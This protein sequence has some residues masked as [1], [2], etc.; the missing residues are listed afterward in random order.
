MAETS[1]PIAHMLKYRMR[2]WSCQRWGPAAEK[3]GYG[4]IGRLPFDGGVEPCKGLL[5]FPGVETVRTTCVLGISGLGPFKCHNYLIQYQ[6]SRSEN[7]ENGRRKLCRC[8][9]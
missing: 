9:T 3:A 8:L 1:L 5:L 7:Q 6:E 2:F 4:T